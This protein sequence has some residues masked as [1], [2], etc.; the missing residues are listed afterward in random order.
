M[1]AS[2]YQ[3]GGDD[4]DTSISPSA[5]ANMINH[6]GPTAR[7]VHAERARVFYKSKFLQVVFFILYS[8]TVRVQVRV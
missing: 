4:N 6:P 2:D 1:E 3:C 7:L 8:Y 5:P